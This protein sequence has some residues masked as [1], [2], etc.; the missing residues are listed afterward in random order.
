MAGTAEK[1]VM[2]AVAD[3]NHLEGSEAQIIVVLYAPVIFSL[4]LDCTTVFSYY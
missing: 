1:Y 2:V 3:S 4:N